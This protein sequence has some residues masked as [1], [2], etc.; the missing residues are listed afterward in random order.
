MSYLPRSL[1]RLI[2]EINVSLFL[3]H[4]QR[5][6]VW[7]KE[8]MQRLFDSLMRNYPIQTFLFW[9][10]QDG[11]R[12][13]RFMDKVE[14][15]A[16]LSGLYAEAKSEKGIEKTF[17]LDGQQRLQTLYALFAGSI[18]D[19]KTQ[20]VL[21]AYADVT[22]EGRPGPDGMAFP[23]RF[24][25]E[26][27]GLQWYRLRALTS[28]DQQRSA[29]DIAEN[30]NERLEVMSDGL[31]KEALKT[32][33]KSVRKNVSQIVSL[34]REDKHFWIEELDGVANNYPYSLVLDI[35]VRVNSGGTKLDAADLMFAAMKQKWDAIEEQVESVADS[36]NEQQLAFDKSLPLKCL[37][38]TH[39]KGAELTPEKFA[40]PAGDE[41]LNAI[42]TRWDDAESAFEQLRDFIRNDL[43]LFS[44]RVVQS[45]GSFVPLLDFLFHNPKPNEVSRKL[46]AAYYY[47]AQLFG[48]FSS[49]T[50]TVINAMH[51]VVGKPCGG[52]FPIGDI[53]AYFA[54]SGY[55]V[56]LNDDHLRNVRHRFMLLN[57][58]YLDQFGTSP[59]N[60]KYRGNEPHIDH[61]YPQAS[62]RSHFLLGTDEVNHLGNYRFVGA[63]D[64]M[65]KNKEKPAEYFSRLRD[66]GVPIGK[67][68]LLEPEADDPTLLKW[69]VETYRHFRDR[70]LARVKEIA[71]RVVNAEQ[72]IGQ[73]AG[74]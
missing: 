37:V 54:R 65:R 23:L 13:R 74:R 58:V 39:G 2:Q 8:Q 63:T 45:Y 6:F 24:A 9:R 57:I 43:G 12:A 33:E 35:F 22:A 70:R 29:H 4:I 66:A 56:L 31:S 67:H 19:A 40:G 38:V 36:L 34:L 1:F 49:S 26:S 51:G 61:I 15:D 25:A 60:V 46:M 21:E 53:K 7:E 59:F 20:Q 64:N 10:T 48:W 50:D 55:E 27:P 71:E 5:P 18:V 14:W 32:R 62:L 68:L 47:K 52:V 69:D 42:S 17:V 16:N 28:S 44:D 3:P 11:I 30:L 72:P 41:L 73:G